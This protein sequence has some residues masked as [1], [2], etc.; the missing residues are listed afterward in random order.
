MSNIFVSYSHKDLEIVTEVVNELKK[1][2][3]LVW[4]D[5]NEIEGGDFWEEN[6]ITGIESATVVL[7]F[8]S[9][10]YLTSTYCNKEL[11]IARSHT[12]KTILVIPLDDSFNFF[13]KDAVFLNRIQ[14][15]SNDPLTEARKICDLLSIKPE[16]KKC[17][18]LPDYGNEKIINK[19]FY[20]ILESSERN[21][22]DNIKLLLRFANFLL[23]FEGK[24]FAKIP[25]INDLRLVEIE[26]QV[27]PIIPNEI[28]LIDSDLDTNKSFLLKR[29]FATLFENR[30]ITSLKNPAKIDYFLN[31]NL[32]I[33]NQIIENRVKNIIDN[34][35]ENIERIQDIVLELSNILNLLLYL[36]NIEKN[37]H[38]PY[39]VNDYILRFATILHAEANKYED[40]ISSKTIMPL[41]K[42]GEN[43]FGTLKE[44][45]LNECVK[46]YKDKDIFLFGEYGCGKSVMMKNYFMNND[47]TLFINLEKINLHRKSKYIQDLIEANPSFI[48]YSYGL[49]FES[50]IKYSITE[51]RLILLIDGLDDLPK[52]IK[53]QLLTEIDELKTSFTI[54]V[55]SRS[56]STFSGI[57]L[58]RSKEEA[59]TA[60]I[61]PLDK[62]RIVRYLEFNGF[63]ETLIKELDNTNADDPFFLTF[64]TFTKL[65][66]LASILKNSAYKNLKSIQATL[67]NEANVYENLIEGKEEYSV[68][69]QILA[70]HK[71]ND[72]NIRDLLEEAYFRDIQRLKEISY[73]KNYEAIENL[74]F[75]QVFLNYNL[76]L[77]NNDTLSISNDVN[78]YLLSS[79]IKEKII[80]LDKKYNEIECLLINLNKNYKILSYLCYLGIPN[81]EFL[82]DL[83]KETK[84]SEYKD[85]KLILF[86]ICQ[87]D[88]RLSRYF[89][90]ITDIE[91][92]P[93]NFFDNF[94]NIIEVIVPKSVKKVGRA[95]FS[96]MPRLKKI[97]FLDSPN[98]IE[99]SSWAIVSCSNLE[100]ITLP[101]G[102]VYYHHPLFRHTPNLSRLVVS[103]DNASFDVL[104]EKFL[105]S[106]NH[107]VLY[108]TASKTE[109]N[110]FVPRC[111]ETIGL[112]ALGY[113]SCVEEINIAKETTDI[114]TDFT[115]FDDRL[116]RFNVEKDNPKYFSKNGIMYEGHTVFRVPSGLSGDLIIPEG[117]LEIGSDSIS[118]CTKLQNVVLPKSLKRIS[119]YGFADTTS[120]QTIRFLN[121]DTLRDV[122]ISQLVFLSSNPYLSINIDGDIYSI[123]D[124][125]KFMNINKKYEIAIKEKTID[126]SILPGDYFETLNLL[127]DEKIYKKIIVLRNISLFEDFIVDDEDSYNI[128]IFGLTEYNYI[129][130]ISSQSVIKN[131]EEL[132]TSKHL[133]AIIFTRDLPI[134]DEI[135]EFKNKVSILRTSLSSVKTKNKLEDVF[136]NSELSIRKGKV[137]DLDLILDIAN[138]AFRPV[139]DDNFDFRIVQKLIYE[140]SRDYSPFH[141]I[142][143]KDGKDVGVVGNIIKNIGKTFKYGFVGT[144]SVLP[145]YQKQGIMTSMLEC[146]HEQNIE[147]EVDASFLTGKRERYNH[148]GYEV[149]GKNICY[150]Y[151]FSQDDLKNNEIEFVEIDDENLF[152][153]YSIYRKEE[154]NILRNYD[155]F[156]LSLS[157][158]NAISKA[159]VIDENVIGYLVFDAKKKRVIEFYSLEK[160]KE[161]L[162]SILAKWCKENSLEEITIMSTAY[163]QTFRNVLNVHEYLN[164][165]GKIYN[166]KNFLEFVCKLDLKAGII[167]DGF[168]LNKQIGDTKVSI[169]I[170]K[171]VN[172][173]VENY[174]VENS[175]EVI[176]EL[177]NSDDSVLKFD[178]P[179]IDYF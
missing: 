113:M 151:S 14:R 83:F 27:E 179:Y 125:N 85:L 175:I 132:I 89:A 58:T 68:V 115:D 144:V 8:L 150:L 30:I 157:Q 77:N 145:N 78:L 96:R 178:I 35:Y 152:D 15:I 126:L 130:G 120:L 55:F 114:E 156:K 57:S 81:E 121:A 87:F 161:I 12:N 60:E 127:R 36:N 13:D 138:S 146:L 48:E 169:S 129:N 84:A 133:N 143:S 163:S 63:N 34:C 155:D 16:V 131:L 32:K 38:K 140:N 162:L 18:I 91:E 17:K 69:S 5:K 20:F 137:G 172:V 118:T 41:I 153:V 76:L 25:D 50:L 19:S 111:I 117:V 9:K 107:K 110:I 64:N 139:R 82:D 119:N 80:S 149:I 148:F 168:N 54:I 47:L 88:K 31:R 44:N 40:E 105:V 106:K 86:K 123:K 135:Y 61:L 158:R 97:T 21:Y 102:Y 100:E 26:G 166:L 103:S 75:N 176:A 22:L 134:I 33:K 45:P 74:R 37:E 108:I 29:L 39:V 28:E 90:H 104:E 109:K 98:E 1:R 4:F 67:L 10:N 43:V 122:D 65:L 171:N 11:E 93:D 159:I 72:L 112:N 165:M 174:S 164:L 167:S 24:D 142:A 160:G 101:K 2:L 128:L 124:F 147:L 154:L 71:F 136:M 59:I 92:L 170:D 46:E 95:V 62:E 49:N 79:Y 56:K 51:K 42:V 116:I 177:F 99:I 70:E 53:N 73:G 6:I 66:I 23:Q 7:V 173:E 94:E 3:F 52:E 141:L